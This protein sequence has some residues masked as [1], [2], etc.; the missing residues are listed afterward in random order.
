MTNYLETEHPDLVLIYQ[1]ALNV[2]TQ[3]PYKATAGFGIMASYIMEQVIQYHNL[4]ILTSISWRK[5]TWKLRQNGLLPDYLVPCFDMIFSLRSK[6]VYPQDAIT[7][8]E[9]IDLLLQWFEQV[10]QRP[11]LKRLKPDIATFLFGFDWRVLTIAGIFCFFA[12]LIVFSILNAVDLLL[13]NTVGLLALC[14]FLYILARIRKKH[15]SLGITKLA[16]A[17]IEWGERVE[18]KIKEKLGL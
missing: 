5:K 1:E 12:L 4:P 6:T 13:G 2:L 15:G 9:N 18:E 10:M 11:P 14:T 17:C 7:A 3:N 16:E 8:R